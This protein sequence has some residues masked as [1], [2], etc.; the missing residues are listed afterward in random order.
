[1]VLA[2]FKL[3][4]IDQIYSAEDKKANNSEL[5]LKILNKVLIQN[6]NIDKQDLYQTN[7]EEIIK[8][9][10]KIK[11]LTKVA[12]LEN[13]LSE[14][15]PGKKVSVKDNKNGTQTILIM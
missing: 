6:K 2:A 12:R 9:K 1:M 10:L 3:M 14:A 11:M 8:E 5:I 15:F 7:K 4:I 13:I